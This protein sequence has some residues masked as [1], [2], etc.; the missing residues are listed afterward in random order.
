VL[1]LDHLS[2]TIACAAVPPAVCVCLR[3]MQVHGGLH[4]DDRL[5]VL[6]DFTDGAHL[7]I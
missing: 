6:S 3:G 7:R 5:A 1:F 4:P 2:L